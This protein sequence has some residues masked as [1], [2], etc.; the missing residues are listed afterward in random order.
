MRI[1]LYTASKTA[2]PTGWAVNALAP[3]VVTGLLLSAVPATALDWGVDVGTGLLATDNLQRSKDAPLDANISEANARFALRESTR[4]LDIDA[5]GG[6][7]HRE[8]DARGISADT[9]PSVNAFLQWTLAPERFAWVVVENA[10]QRAINPNDGLLPSDRENVNIVGTGPEFQFALDGGSWITTSARYSRVDYQESPLDST[11]LA[12]R[13]GF[14]H[15]LESGN[16]WSLNF[17]HARTEFSETAT[18]FYVQSLYAGFASKGPLGVLDADLGVSSLHQADG[19]RNGYFADVRLDRQLSSHTE[20]SV[21]LVH[22][23]ADSADVFRR[24]QDLEPDIEST[25]DVIAS[26]QSLRETALDI[27]VAWMGRRTR[28]A[29]GGVYFDEKFFNDDVSASRSGAGVYALGE[30]RLLQRLQLQSRF[31]WRRE[32][33]ELEDPVHLSQVQVSLYWQ[34]TRTLG[35]NLGAEHYLRDGSDGSTANYDENRYF[36]ML[37]WRVKELDAPH[38]RPRIDTPASRRLNKARQTL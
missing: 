6:V 15:E 9:L 34:F 3:V 20:I 5:V 28:L 22:R 13:V 19:S 24:R 4:T 16:V 17:A 31:E 38:M 32:A 10:G 37:D 18:H 33:P 29:L 1:P 14:E 23:F 8:Y 11:R 12:G 2:R 36:L 25:A 26:D 35:L 30:M 21:D 7:I 27:G